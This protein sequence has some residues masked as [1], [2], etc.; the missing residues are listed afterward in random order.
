MAR[1]RK[2]EKAFGKLFQA[3]PKKPSDPH[4]KSR[5]K[6]K[7]LA[8]EHGI[9]VEKLAEGGMNVWAP[10]WV[11]EAQDPFAG[12][13]FANDWAEALSMIEQYIALRAQA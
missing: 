11:P 13:H 4:R 12:D 5:T 6:A 7:L 1:L 9:E 10:D 3:S 8:A 2:L